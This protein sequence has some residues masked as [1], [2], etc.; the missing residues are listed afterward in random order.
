METVG[1]LGHDGA[2][3]ACSL[4]RGQRV[5]T[6]VWSRGERD[7]ASLLRYRPVSRRILKE[8]IDRS[9]LDGVVL[10][11]QATLAA[12]GRDATLRGHPRARKRQTVA[13]SREQL[14]GAPYA[15]TSLA[16][17]APVC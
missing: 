5:M 6:R 2:Q 17:H 14:G 10:G 8:G 16:D 9:N 7:S 1:V 3:P 11:P 13:S 4:K 12:K 15:H